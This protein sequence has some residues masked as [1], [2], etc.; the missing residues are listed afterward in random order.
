MD[1]EKLRCFT[2]QVCLLLI[3]K[4]WKNRLVEGLL[5]DFGPVA[6]IVNRLRI[7]ADVEC[8]ATLMRL[9]IRCVVRAPGLSTTLRYQCTVMVT[10]NGCDAYTNPSFLKAISPGMPISLKAFTAPAWANTKIA[11]DVRV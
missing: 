11:V 9:D 7:Q 8:N 1:V 3:R 4:T 6:G 10:R 5:D 2:L